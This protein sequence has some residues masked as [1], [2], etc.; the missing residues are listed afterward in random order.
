MKTSRVE[1]VLVIF[2]VLFMVNQDN[3]FYLMILPGQ[4]PVY[5]NSTIITFGNGVKREPNY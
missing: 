1:V 2:Y 5:L 4:E 3:S